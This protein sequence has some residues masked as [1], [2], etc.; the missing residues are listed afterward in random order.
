MLEC[1]RVAFCLE[2][3][4]FRPLVLLVSS[5][6]QASATGISGTS[7]EQHLQMS[8]D[9]RVALDVSCVP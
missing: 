1:L 8:P 2:G 9:T 6:R 7:E 3:V 5:D 4:R